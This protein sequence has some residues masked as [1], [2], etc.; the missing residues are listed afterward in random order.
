MLSVM[1]CCC[2]IVVL[3]VL[4][5]VT[6]LIQGMCAIHDPIT[7]PAVNVKYF[8]HMLRHAVCA[9]LPAGQMNGQHESHQP[10]SFEQAKGRRKNRGKRV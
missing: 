4:G 9:V 10:D 7:V 2:V 8:W 1:V 6:C 3:Y 5:S